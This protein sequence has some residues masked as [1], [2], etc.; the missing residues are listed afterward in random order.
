MH[1]VTVLT[2]LLYVSQVAA[3]CV[4][5]RFF[6]IL[7]CRPEAAA[8]LLFSVV[9]RYPKAASGSLQLRLLFEQR[10]DMNFACLTEDV[11]LRR[12]QGSWPGQRGFTVSS[13]LDHACSAT[14]Q[15]APIAAGPRSGLTDGHVS[16]LPEMTPETAQR[17]AALLAPHL[18]AMRAVTAGTRYEA[19]EAAGGAPG[20]GQAPGP[21]ISPATTIF[22][23]GMLELT[24]GAAL[25]AG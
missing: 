23:A 14:G 13:G 3:S 6:V 18:V 25:P 10:S 8:R 21:G 17:L 19:C 15:R 20:P 7:E 11:K 22:I 12:Q 9:R 1:V 2:S 4:L 5:A 24:A 16:G